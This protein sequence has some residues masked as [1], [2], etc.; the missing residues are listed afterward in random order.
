MSEEYQ[1][2]L[3]L[4]H[5]KLDELMRDQ[6]KMEE[7]FHES[8]HKIEELEAQKKDAARQVRDMNN[9]FESER[10]AMLRDR[11]EQLAR[12]T[13]HKSTIQRLKETLAGREMRIN[14]DAERRTS[15]SGQLMRGGFSDSWADRI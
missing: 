11:E 6:A 2:E 3:S 8:S 9:V 5:K 1:R 13:E 12:E 15:K 14:A 4:V 7:R 10:M